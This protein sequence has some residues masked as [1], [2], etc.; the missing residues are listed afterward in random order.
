[1]NSRR[2]V[3]A[4]LLTLLALVVAVWFGQ[5]AA[6]QEDRD[7]GP[8]GV[9]RSELPVR[10]LS[11]LP[12]QAAEVWWLIRAGGPFPHEQ[13]GATFVNREQLLPSRE[14]GYYREYTVPTPGEA[15][16]GPRRLVTGRQAEL[17]YTADHYRSFVAVDPDR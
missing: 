4:A 1:M 8:A 12:P 11:D 3:S 15:D 10:A 5:G 13:D 6:S 7:G 17:Y 14:A 16:R 9:V 2:R